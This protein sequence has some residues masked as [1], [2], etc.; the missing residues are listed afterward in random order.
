MLIKHLESIL[1]I[2]VK[3][4]RKKNLPGCSIE[5]P[6]LFIPENDVFRSKNVMFAKINLCIRLLLLRFVL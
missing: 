1:Q 2:N 4:H 5:R 6:F 3:N